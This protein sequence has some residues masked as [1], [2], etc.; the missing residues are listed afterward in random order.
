MVV[1]AYRKIDPGLKSFIILLLFFS[2]LCLVMLVVVLA[3]YEAKFKALDE[4][5]AAVEMAEKQVMPPISAS[6]SNTVEIT[7]IGEYNYWNLLR[8]RDHEEGVT[9]YWLGES[10]S[11]VDIT[12]SG[13]K[14]CQSAS[15]SNTK[16][17]P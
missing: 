11:C 9:C 7:E 14:R 13:V 17:N 5:E 15:R 3:S 2:L 16:E 10:I 8:V 6:R 4:R 12:A 1:P